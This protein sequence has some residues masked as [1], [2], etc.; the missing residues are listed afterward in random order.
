MEA[1]DV[2]IIGFHEIL[3]YSGHAFISNLLEVSML[4]VVQA[5]S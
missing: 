4:H 5:R 2:I 1:L 3:Q